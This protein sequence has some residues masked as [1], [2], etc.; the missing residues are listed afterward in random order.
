[1]VLV[2]SVWL[3]LA[4]CDLVLYNKIQY[5]F[6]DYISS[7]NI[8]KTIRTIRARRPYIVSP[9]CEWDTQQMTAVTVNHT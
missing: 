5:G 6:L 8:Y 2:G 3:A 7:I 9:A 4:W 1:M